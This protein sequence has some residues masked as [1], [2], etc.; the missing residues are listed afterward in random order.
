MG[1]VMQPELLITKGGVDLFKRSS[2]MEKPLGQK[3]VLFLGT[4]ENIVLGYQTGY[5][6]GDPRG[7]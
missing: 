2:R 4:D 1:I 7:R 6:I 3:G 5:G